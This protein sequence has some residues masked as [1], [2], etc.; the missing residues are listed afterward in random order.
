MY[1]YFFVSGHRDPVVPLFFLGFFLLSHMH[2]RGEKQTP[3]TSS[4]AGDIHY[5]LHLC[6]DV[7]WRL[8]HKQRIFCFEEEK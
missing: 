2:E 1:F 3:R 7:T 6:A 4:L 8:L 5:L